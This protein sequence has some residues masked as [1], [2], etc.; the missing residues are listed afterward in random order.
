MSDLSSTRIGAYFLD[1]MPQRLKALVEEL[2]RANDIHA[3]ELAEMRA[4][5]ELHAT[6]N[7]LLREQNQILAKI[8]E[9]KER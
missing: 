7:N 5:N 2:K 3:Q 6:Q 8:A 9:E 1:V 4:A